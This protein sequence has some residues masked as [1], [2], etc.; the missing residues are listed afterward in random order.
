MSKVY[1]AAR[2]KPAAL[3]VFLENV[4][5][6]SG[7]HLPGW[8]MQAIDF[9][10]EEYAKLLLHLLGAHRRYDRVV[11]LEDEAATGKSLAQALLALSRT[12]TVD[13]LLL[14]HGKERQLVGYRA[15]DYV[16]GATWEY[17]RALYRRDRTLLDLRMVYG[18]NCYGASL[19]ET[20]LGLGAQAVNGAVG[21]NWFPEPS[22]STFLSNWLGGRPFSYAVGRANARANRWWG[23]LLGDADH[24]W[25]ASSRQMIY[26]VRD[27]TI[28][29]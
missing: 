24:P 6:I 9:T 8:A 3:L 28:D 12:H 20:W 13:L 7:L 22:L 16:D 10:T 26:G 11:V 14:V 23:R 19:A 21:V 2:Q 25:I 27:V 5:H 29:T 1:S 4:G 15:A 17:L 18:L